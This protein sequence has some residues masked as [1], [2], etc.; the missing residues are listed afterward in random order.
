MGFLNFSK[1]NQR[2]LEVKMF[3]ESEKPFDFD[4]KSGHVIQKGSLR[5]DGTRRK[6]RTVKIAA[7]VEQRFPGWFPKQKYVAP[8]LRDEEYEKMKK[9]MNDLKITIID[10]NYQKKEKLLAYL[11]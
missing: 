5:P 10:D 11:N 7:A 4:E 1:R 3:E 6:D 9:R 8:H 2:Q